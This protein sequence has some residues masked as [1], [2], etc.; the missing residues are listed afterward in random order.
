MGVRLTMIKFVLEGIHVYWL[1][2]A[3]IPYAIL[4]TLEKKMFSFLWYGN[5]IK[6]KFHLAKWESI[7]RPKVLGG[8]WLKIYLCLEN[9]LFLREYGERYLGGWWFKIYLCLENP[10]LLREYGERY[11]VLGFDVL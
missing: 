6:E 8:W 4:H 10:L 7:A 9:P 1:S 11:L 2:L 3:H 5:A